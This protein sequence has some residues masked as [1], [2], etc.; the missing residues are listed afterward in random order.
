MRKLVSVI[1]ASIL[2]CLGSLAMADPVTEVWTCTLNDGK[3]AE[4]AHAVG[5]KWV[6]IARKLTGSDEITSSF[7]T[8]VVGDAGNFMWV[9]TYPSLS[10]WAQAQELFGDSDEYTSVGAALD[11]LE[12]CS[13]NRLYS[14]TVVD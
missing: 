3:T 12:S 1:S 13:A 14:G 11:E 4:D 6:A 8:T 2:L 5:K 7:V 9:D 10:V